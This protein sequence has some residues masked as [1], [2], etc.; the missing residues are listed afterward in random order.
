MLSYKVQAVAPVKAALLLL[1]K[2]KISES[3]GD[4]RNEDVALMVDHSGSVQITGNDIK[5]VSSQIQY[6][7]AVDSDCWENYSRGE[8]F[9]GH[10]F[11]NLSKDSVYKNLH[12]EEKNALR[13]FCES[14]VNM[15]IDTEKN[16]PVLN[17]ATID[18]LQGM[19]LALNCTD[20]KEFEEKNIFEYSNWIKEFAWYN[21]RVMLLKMDKEIAEESIALPLR[22]YAE[23]LEKGETKE[24]IRSYA[25]ER[26][27]SL[28]KESKKEDKGKEKDLDLSNLSI[29]IVD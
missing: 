20:K 29:D 19:L 9:Q 26:A 18:N 4:E 1:E 23:G 21:S 10:V 3:N 25:H 16:P 6:V 11:K 5:K 2:E 22:A 28:L 27:I 8:P 14:W 12:E 7:R 13:M 15:K 24:T 17:A